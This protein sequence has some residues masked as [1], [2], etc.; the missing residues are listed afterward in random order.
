MLLLLGLLLLLLRLLRLLAVRL[1]ATRR[2][3]RTLLALLLL[4]RGSLSLRLRLLEALALWRLLELALLRLLEL[5][6][7]RRRWIGRSRQAHRQ[8]RDRSN[9][10]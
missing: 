10:Q 8:N 2:G 1:G 9:R 7:L 3:Q 5:P 6:L 4:R